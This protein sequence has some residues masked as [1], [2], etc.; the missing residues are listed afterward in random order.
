M[1]IYLWRAG[2]ELPSLAYPIAAATAGVV[3]GTLIGERLLFGLSSDQ[4]RRIVGAL[5]GILGVWLLMQ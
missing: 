3:A 5:I 2:S 4:F 1:P